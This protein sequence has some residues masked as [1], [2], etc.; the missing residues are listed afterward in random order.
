MNRETLMDAIGQLPEDIIA[1][2]AE[3]RVRKK[4]RWTHWAALAACLCLV[5]T[6]PLAVGGGMKASNKAEMEAPMEMA[7]AS[8]GILRDWFYGDSVQDNG[9]DMKVPTEHFLATVVEVH[10]LYLLV[11]PLED[12]WEHSSA[13]RIEVPIPNPQDPQEF[14]VGDLLRI[15]YSGT[16]RESYPAQAVGV[17]SIER[18]G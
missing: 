17:Y 12:E 9:S 6:L 18:L 5:L 15:T 14:A 10:E 11:E 7:P 2:A 16:L 4:T 13:N 3:K 8:E 1:E